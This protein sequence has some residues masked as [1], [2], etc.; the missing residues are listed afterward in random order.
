MDFVFDRVENI[1]EKGEYA[2]VQHFLLF[3]QY[4]SGVIILRSLGLHSNFSLPT[5]PEFKQP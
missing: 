3:P 2:V 5:K 1:V 4:F